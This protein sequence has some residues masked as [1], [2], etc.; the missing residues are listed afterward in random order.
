[1]NGGLEPSLEAASKRERGRQ[2]R[3]HQ[4]DIQRYETETARELALGGPRDAIE[5]N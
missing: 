4:I 1:M 3:R 2:A 5:K